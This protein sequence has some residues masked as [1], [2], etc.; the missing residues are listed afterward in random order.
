MFSISLHAFFVVDR[1]PP[2]CQ[3]GDDVFQ[4]IPLNA[5]GA[6]IIFEECQATDNSGIVTLASRSHSPGQRFPT[7]VTAVEYVFSDPSDNTVNCRVTITIV[8]GLHDM[9]NVCTFAILYNW[10]LVLCNVFLPSVLVLNCLVMMIIFCVFRLFMNRLSQVTVYC[11]SFMNPYFLFICKWSCYMS[12][13]QMSSFCSHPVSIIA[14]HVVNRLL[15][16][17]RSML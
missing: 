13:D 10:L 1:V 4:Q 7:G 5:G 17:V 2:V 6:T 11:S 9:I 15:Q 16:D 3:C 8:E 12:N 14:N